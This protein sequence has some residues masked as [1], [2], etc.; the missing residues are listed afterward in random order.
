MS[1]RLRFFFVDAFSQGAFTG[2]V[3]GVV[4][5]ADGLNDLQ[6][7]RIA[8]EANASETAFVSRMND[9]HRPPRLRW[10]TPTTEV[11][12]CGHAT[13]GAA[14]ALAE[15]EGR[16]QHLL[17]SPDAKLSFETA[18]GVLSLGATP[19]GD[20]PDK[21]EWWLEMPDPGLEPV[22]LNP[23][24]TCE[25]LGLSLEALDEGVPITGTRDHDVIL[26]AKSWAAL[27]ELRPDYQGLTRWSERH[28]IRGFCVATLETLSAA[29]QVQARFFAPAVGVN[30]DPVTGS[31]QGPLAVMLA[32]HGLVPTAAGR[33]TL[34]CVQGI[35]G[36]RAGLVRSVV[37]SEGGGP[38]VWIGGRC[39]TTLVGEMVVPP[40]E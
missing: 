34:T 23:M 2:N 14:H 12:F 7:R 8:Q 28:G 35:P 16:V 11:G 22:N 3:A 19:V 38:R 33:A 30:E 40:T 39:E 20:A 18:A 6:M 21:P 26:L 15:L 32:Q 17:S 10:F 31:V 1:E 9:L 29:I 27:T 4:L 5:A 24:K 13:L 25:Y 36:G 37:E